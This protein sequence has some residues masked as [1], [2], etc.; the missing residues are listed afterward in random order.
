M[1][2]PPLDQSRYAFEGK[3]FYYLSVYCDFVLRIGPVT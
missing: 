3:G 1:Q 2:T